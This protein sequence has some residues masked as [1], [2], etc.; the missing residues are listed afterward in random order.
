MPEHQRRTVIVT[1]MS[2]AGRTTC[3]KILEDLG[4]EAVDNLPVGLLDRLLGAEDSTGPD[5]A[6]GVDSRTRDFEASRLVAMIERHRADGL[7]PTLLYLECDDAVLQRRFS[8]TRRR[9]PM[10]E[11]G[12]IS[13]ALLLERRIMTPLRDAADIVLDTSELPLPDLRRV[14]EGYF[15]HGGSQF[16]VSVV[17]FSFKRGLPRE[18]DLVFDVRFLRNPHYVETLRPQTGLDPAVQAYV[19][20]DPDFAGFY[21]RLEQLLLPLLPRYRSEGKSYLTIAVGCTGGKHR[22]VFVAERLGGKLREQGWDVRT[23]HREIGT[24]TSPRGASTAA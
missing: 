9:H 6:V 11:A 13:D 17:S 23:V 5:L 4:F 19:A 2:G 14:L 7:P 20:E 18:A 21:A 22:S 12:A 24:V 15:P 3:L 16:S 1:G 10:G 8:E